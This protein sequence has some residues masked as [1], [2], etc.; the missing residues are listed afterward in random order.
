[1]LSQ[2]KAGVHARVLGIHLAG[3]W[4]LA[5]VATILKRNVSLADQHAPSSAP[6]SLPVG[7]WR[8]ISMP[9]NC[10]AD[11]SRWLCKVGVA[12]GCPRPPDE[13]GRAL[14]MHSAGTSGVGS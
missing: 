8:M 2:R 12:A 10:A 14:P 1:M 13:C 11:P 7:Y 4:R 6:R 3:T 9:W 5:A